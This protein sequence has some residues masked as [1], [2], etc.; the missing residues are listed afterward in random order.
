MCSEICAYSLAKKKTGMNAIMAINKTRFSTAKGRMRKISTLMS[1]DSV[2]S[3]T[4]TKTPMI[5]R[6]AMMQIHVHGL[7]HPQGTDCCRPKMLS[8]IPAAMRTAPR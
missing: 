7:L 4:R 5:T 3:S 2:R 1:G 6:P 8:P